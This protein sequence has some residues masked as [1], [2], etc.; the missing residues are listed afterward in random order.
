MYHCQLSVKGNWMR[1]A[2][3][4]IAPQFFALGLFLTL[5]IWLRFQDS[6]PALPL[7]FW[8]WVPS[9]SLLIAAALCFAFNR[10]QLLLATLL[11]AAPLAA[12]FLNLNATLAEFLLFGVIPANFLLLSALRERGS[13]TIT[14]ISR[15]ALFLAQAGVFVFAPDWLDSKLPTTL[16]GLDGIVDWLPLSQLNLL[17]LSLASMVVVLR[18]YLDSSPGVNGLTSAYMAYLLALLLPF[19]HS[20]QVFVL[21]GAMLILLAIVRESHNLAYRDELTGLPQRRA[22]NEQLAALGGRYTL[23]MLDVDHFKKFN[24]TH[25]HDIGDQVLQMVAARIRQ[26]KGGGKAYRYGGE[27]FSIVF[28]RKSK[29]DAFHFLDEVRKSVQDYEMVVR[30]KE[31]IDEDTDGKSQRQRGSFRSAEKKVSVTISIGVAQREGRETA[32]EVLK[33]ADEA[34]YRAKKAGRNTVME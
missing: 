8:S 6:V 11:L 19:N 14:G 13:W 23:A 21:A 26:V 24:D 7:V 9:V 4:V 10:G 5:V 31:R 16:P 32:E 30:S 27:E 17:L 29:D 20:L 34:L 22:L 15:L 28:A 2:E 33:R 12:P 25:G 18:N 3:R 1:F